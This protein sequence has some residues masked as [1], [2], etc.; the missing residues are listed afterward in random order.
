[1]SPFVVDGPAELGQ[2]HL[3]VLGPWNRE[4]GIQH[5]PDEGDDKRDVAC[6]A[7]EETTVQ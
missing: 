3:A 5:D 4:D 7:A 6:E 2:S 1:M